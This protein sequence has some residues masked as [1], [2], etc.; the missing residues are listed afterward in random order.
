MFTDPLLFLKSSYL[1][2]HSYRINNHNRA[3]TR[4][5]KVSQV[6]WKVLIKIRLKIQK[7]SKIRLNVINIFPRGVIAIINSFSRF[8]D[9]TIRYSTPLISE[10]IM[11]E[12]IQKYSL[13]QNDIKYKIRVR[14]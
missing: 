11:F 10:L 9:P 2:S 4:N 14:K 8:V 7:Q 13:I 6:W 1:C 3:S 12:N 5:V